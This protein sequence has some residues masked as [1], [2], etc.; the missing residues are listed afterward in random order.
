MG[1]NESKPRAKYLG[2]SEGKIT[3]RLQEGEHDP[4][5]KERTIEQTGN[6]V[7]E[8]IYDNVEG[9]LRNI[10]IGSSTFQGKTVEKAQWKF[11][12]HDDGEDF[13]LTMP[14]SSSYA[15][16]VLNA[17]ANV[18]DFDQILRLRPWKMANPDK[19][20][21]Y[22]LGIT[23]YVAP[24][25]KDDKVPK[26]YCTAKAK[27]D[28]NGEGMIAELPEMVKA[29][30]KQ[31]DVWDDE[32]QMLFFERVVQDEILPRIQEAAGASSSPVIDDAPADLST[33]HAAAT[34][35]KNYDD[36]PF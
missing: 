21:K 6:V 33:E 28:G 3:R 22:W 1:L 35:A 17:L 13:M 4:K 19:A 30:I 25:T 26:K 32:E 15:K 11:H 14:Y 16:S 12:I 31:Q 23:V 24:Y 34:T 9:Y 36:V 18:K 10:E 5:A 20:D 7:R 8:L 2:V 29:R 27:A